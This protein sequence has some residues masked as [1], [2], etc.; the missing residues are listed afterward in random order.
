[1]ASEKTRLDTLLVELGYFNSKQKAQTC[2]MSNGVTIAGK[3]TNKPGMQINLEKFYEALETNPD[4]LSVEDKLSQYVSRGALKLK[5]AHEAF[6]LDFED[7]LVLDIGASTGGFTDYALQQGASQVIALDVGKGQLHYKLQNHPQ[8]INLEGINFRDW[9]GVI[10]S[11]QGKPDIT[12]SCDIVVTDVSFISLIKILEQ[13]LKI[14]CTSLITS[15]NANKERL[16][17]IALIKPQFEAGKE[18]MDKCQGVIRDEKIRAK[19]LEETLMKIDKLGYKFLGIVES[20]IK[21]AKGNVEY[22]V[23]LDM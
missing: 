7:K 5:A 14:F 16:E 19:V 17:I 18:I 23:Y 13:L 9:D 4:H 15:S 3:L 22:L 12:F 1:L 6:G 10:A 21:G 8:V 11:V 20:P 2:I